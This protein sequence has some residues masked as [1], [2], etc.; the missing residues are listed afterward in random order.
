M[1]IGSGFSKDWD[2]HVKFTK[3]VVSAWPEWQQTMLGGKPISPPNG[4][5]RPKVFHEVCIRP[6]GKYETTYVGSGFVVKI[7]TVNPGQRLSLQRHRWRDE[8]WFI[9]E[10]KADVTIEGVNYGLFTYNHINIANGKWHRVTNNQ[11]TPLVLIEVQTG[12]CFEEDI[13]RLE[14]DYNRV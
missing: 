5:S 2:E 3:E 12:N 7:I 10:G 11:Q 4:I 14:D 8:H 9:V 13:E 6:W 1:S